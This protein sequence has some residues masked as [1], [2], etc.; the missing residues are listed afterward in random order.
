MEDYLSKGRLFL[1]QG[2]EVFFVFYFLDF[3]FIFAYAKLVIE[4]KRENRRM[5][6]QLEKS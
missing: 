5:F 3:L 1:G 4:S 2:R 6:L